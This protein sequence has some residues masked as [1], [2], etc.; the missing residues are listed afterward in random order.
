VNETHEPGA[1]APASE[2]GT[3]ES[4]DRQAVGEARVTEDGVILAVDQKGKVF[5]C[6]QINCWHCFAKCPRRA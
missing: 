1:T 3:D 6:P 4:G 5:K 2:A